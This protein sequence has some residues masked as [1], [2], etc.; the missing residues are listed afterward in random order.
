MLRYGL[1]RVCGKGFPS[2][3]C[4]WDPGPLPGVSHH[5]PPGSLFFLQFWSRSGVIKLYRL[6]EH[7]F[8]GALMQSLIEAAAKKF[9]I[10]PEVLDLVDRQFLSQTIDE[11][12]DLLLP[13]IMNTLRQEYVSK[14]LES[15]KQN[16]RSLHEQF[17]LLKR[18]YGP[19]WI[20]A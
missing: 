8:E 17:L 7:G 2:D 18:L 6:P 19:K 16:V 13:P 11:F 3:N 14:G 12:P 1:D 9:G 20:L 15:I 5:S 10:P 4:R